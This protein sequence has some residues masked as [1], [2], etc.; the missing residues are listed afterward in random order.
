MSDFSNIDDF[1]NIDKFDDLDVPL[2]ADNHLFSNGPDL[3][4]VQSQGQ[5]LNDTM[6]DQSGGLCPAEMSGS[7]FKN[8]TSEPQAPPSS[9]VEVFDFEF[10]TLNNVAFGTGDHL[11]D[12]AP[13]QYTPQ[14]VPQQADGSGLDLTSNGTLSQ[15]PPTTESTVAPSAL[16]NSQSHPQVM[17]APVATHDGQLLCTPMGANHFAHMPVSPQQQIQSSQ[18]QATI[19]PTEYMQAIQQLRSAQEQL[20]QIV[21]PQTQVP[22]NVQLPLTQESPQDSRQAHDSPLLDQYIESTQYIEPAQYNE[23][24]QHMQTASST[25][26]A[27]ETTDIQPTTTWPLNEQHGKPE[28]LSRSEK[29]RKNRTSRNTR[30]VESEPRTQESEQREPTP[31][32]SGQSFHGLTFTSLQHAKSAMST[33]ILKSDWQAPFPDNTVP[34]TNEDRAHWVLQMF[35]AFLDTSE[36]KDNKNGYS[37]LKRWDGTDYYDL[38]QMEK[39]CWQMC[40]IAE[41]FH[42]RGP[43]ATNIYCEDALKK[44]YCSRILTFEQRIVAICSMLKLSKFL[45]DN[46]MKGEGIEAL[47]GAPKQKMSGAKTMMVQNKKRQGWLVTGRKSDVNHKTGESVKDDEEDLINNMAEIP[48]EIPAEVPAPAQRKPKRKAKLPAPIAAPRSR[49]TARLRNNLSISSESSND[50]DNGD[51]NE[52]DNGHSGLSSPPAPLAQSVSRIVREPKTT[53]THIRAKRGLK[54]AYVASEEAVSPQADVSEPEQPTSRP[55]KRTR[56]DSSLSTTAPVRRRLVHVY[57]PKKRAFAVVREYQVAAILEDDDQEVDEDEEN[58]EDQESKSEPMPSPSPIRKRK[59]DTIPQRG[60]LVMTQPGVA[61]I[62][63]SSSEL[64]DAPESEEEPAPPVKR[65]KVVRESAPAA[66]NIGDRKGGPKR[67]TQG[68]FLRKGRR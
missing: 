3:Y 36:C 41:R 27:P 64:S 50:E 56:T 67:D 25:I 61:E 51:T 66:K 58:D 47:V 4:T 34:I 24:T 44:I 21:H 65:A 30:A 59:R 46:L 31:Q 48:E 60:R 68:R 57:I 49:T 11:S 20:A 62:D 16:I 55:V 23:P 14:S 22:M 33:R 6:Y 15:L 35:D 45:C 8:V 42:E 32:T 28:K 63:P 10:D 54:R 52:S 40:E 37:F 38:Q 12:Y 1:F 29:A 9:N 17:P 18:Q 53:P 19:S 43:S 26:A 5:F 7:S 39:V 2:I 13:D